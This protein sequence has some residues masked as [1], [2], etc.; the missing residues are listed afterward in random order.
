MR[1]SIIF[2]LNLVSGLLVIALLGVCLAAWKSLGEM[3]T[4]AERT[5]S[6]RVQQLQRIASVELLLTRISAQ[7]RNTLLDTRNPGAVTAMQVQLAKANEALGPIFVAYKKEINTPEGEEF[8]ARAVNYKTDFWA[9]AE[10]NIQLMQAGDRDAAFA[11]LNDKTSRALQTWLDGLAGEKEI[12]SRLLLDQIS[13]IQDKAG[14]LR[15]VLAA[16]TAIVAAVLALFSWYAGRILRRRM[17]QAQSVADHIRNG[18]LTAGIQDDAKD[19]FSP[20]LRA[21]AA[22]QASLASVV[23][24]VRHNSEGVATA[25]VQIAQGNKDLSERTETQAGALQQTAATMAQMNSTVGNNTESA[26]QAYQLAQGAVAVA[27]HGGE[28]VGQVVATMQGI[29][30]SSRKIGDIIGVV[31][32]IAFQTNILA[33]NAAVEAARAGEQGRGFAVVASEVRSLAQRSAEAAR[34][35]KAL[36]GGSVDKVEQGSQLVA[37]A[38]QTMDEIV[39]SIQRVN[40]IVGEISSQSVEQS[41]GISQV[42]DSVHQIDLMTQQNAAL[43]EE[44]AAA[45]ESLKSQAQHLLQ[46][47]AVFKLSGENARPHSPLA[48]PR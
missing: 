14:T 29:T 10:A 40:A 12:Q 48:L 18:D 6:V 34:E 43:V 36:I 16:L 20:L 23:G 7:L 4:M 47:V 25:S 19:E 17:N 39:G 9:A 38:G 5:A 41:V 15:A 45:A 35:I 2:R 11:Y 3:S 31:D 30:E 42:V 28:V 44:S 37:Q 33:L 8:F 21:L 27:A 46:A 13:R 26:K 1:L 32:S 22:M 24:A